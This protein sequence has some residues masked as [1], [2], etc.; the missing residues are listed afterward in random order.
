MMQVIN[1]LGYT[2][3]PLCLKLLLIPNQLKENNFGMFSKE[4]KNLSSGHFDKDYLGLGNKQLQDC[5]W[6]HP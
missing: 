5:C 2:E 3:S 4:R 1:L 6:W